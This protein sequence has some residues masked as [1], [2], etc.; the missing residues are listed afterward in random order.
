MQARLHVV[1]VNA[2][3]R[4]ANQAEISTGTDGNGMNG[5]G[6]LLVGSSLSSCT[7]LQLVLALRVLCQPP[8][9]SG[10]RPLM[11]RQDVGPITLTH[12]QACLLLI[13]KR[14]GNLVDSWRV[15]HM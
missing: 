10:C 9:I 8:R 7:W 13:S 12:L 2:A 5:R 4:S 1:A 11:P 14:T 3:R 15:G 6:R